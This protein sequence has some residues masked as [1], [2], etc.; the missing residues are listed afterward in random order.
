MRCEWCKIEF[1]GNK[2]KKFCS[3]SCR[4]YSH[5]GSKWK[6]INRLT[7]QE[8]ELVIKKRKENEQRV[9]KKDL[10]ND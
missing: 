1:V 4:I 7:P 3:D 10:S 9:K 8:W 2:K 6:N 5:R